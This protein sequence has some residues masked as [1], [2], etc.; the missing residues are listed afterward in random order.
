MPSL[1]L[2]KSNLSIIPSPSLSPF[3]SSVSLMPSL[4]SSISQKSEILSPSLS[5]LITV[6]IAVSLEKLPLKSVTVNTTLLGPKWV[7]DNELGKT[8]KVIGLQ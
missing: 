5:L 6:T 1:S 8:L 4:S 2:S 7:Q 3:P